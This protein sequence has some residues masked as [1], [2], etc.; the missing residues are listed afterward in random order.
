MFQLW[1]KFGIEYDLNDL[2][3]IDTYLEYR[4]LTNHN[5]KIGYGWQYLSGKVVKTTPPKLYKDKSKDDDERDT[6]HKDEM[7]DLILSDRESF[8]FKEMQQILK[9]CR[10]DVDPLPDLLNEILIEL[11]KKLRSSSKALPRLRDEI[12]LRG[13]YA[14]RT[15]V[16]EMLGYPLG[17]Q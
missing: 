15:A 12:L 13:K 10:S 5:H 3:F 6:D 11:T 16:M 14:A 2:K 9:Y 17:M 7:R 1:D 8:S 4:M